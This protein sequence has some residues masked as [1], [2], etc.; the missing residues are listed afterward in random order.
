MK[1]IEFKNGQ[2]S[3]RLIYIEPNLYSVSSLWSPVR[4]QGQA[5]AVLDEVIQYADKHGF[6]LTLSAQRYGHPIQTTLNDTQLE[7]LYEKFGFSK[8]GKCKPAF[9]IRYPSQE[10]LVL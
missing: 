8:R 7:E 1:P 2:A 3:V 9:M 4:H 6:T 5:N 10:L